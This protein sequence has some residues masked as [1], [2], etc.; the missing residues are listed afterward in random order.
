MREHPA[1]PREPH[2]PRR[3]SSN[4]A[5]VP[6]TRVGNKGYTTAHLKDYGITRDEAEFM[7]AV[8]KAMN[9]EMDGYNLT[10]SMSSTIK[11]LYDIDDDKLQALGYLKLHT[12]V[13]RRRYYTVTPT[14]Q[15]ACRMT[16]KHGFDIGDPGDD[17]PHRVGVALTRQYYE[18]RDDVRRVEV[19]PNEGGSRTDLVVVDT[20]PERIATIEVEGGR[21]NSD[22]GVPDDV[23]SG[24]NDYWLSRMLLVSLMSSI[25]PGFCSSVGWLRTHCETVPEKLSPRL[26]STSGLRT[27]RRM[28]PDL[29][30]RS[31]ATG[32]PRRTRRCSASKPSSV[33]SLRIVPRRDLRA[34][35]QRHNY[36]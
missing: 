31:T 6:L 10:E 21:I 36:G 32:P 3:Q 29:A 11:T 22:P 30:D 8:V 18:S 17:T 5:P 13:A 23:S 33:T 2:D 25:Q 28:D 1:D 26:A 14:G 16:K 20:E 12:G 15:R 9:G 19:S 4:N 27:A 24:I 34:I 7:Q 35:L